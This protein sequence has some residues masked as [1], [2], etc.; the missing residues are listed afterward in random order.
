LLS[1]TPGESRL[2][3][4][5]REPG[6]KGCVVRSKTLGVKVDYELLSELSG[7]VGARN[8]KIVPVVQKPV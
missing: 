4:H 5:I 3:F 8:I 2:F 7:S 1:R 6:K